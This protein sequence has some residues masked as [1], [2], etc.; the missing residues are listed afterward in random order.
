ME[1][2]TILF[3]VISI[4]FFI[5]WDYF[6]VRKDLQN[7]TFKNKTSVVSANEQ[8]KADQQESKKTSLSAQPVQQNLKTIDTEK[9]HIVLSRENGF[10]KKFLLKNYYKNIQKKDYVD[11]FYTGLYDVYDTLYIN[12]VGTRIVYNDL[13]VA[14][15]NKSIIFNF[16][17]SVGSVDIKK[18]LTVDKSDFKG[19]VYY[20]I[21]PKAPIGQKIS[22]GSAIV[23]SSSTFDSYEEGHPLPLFF[24]NK[25]LEH[26]SEKQLKKGFKALNVRLGGVSEKYFALLFIDEKE[27]M[28]ADST[29]VDGRIDTIL[30]FFEA[31]AVNEPVSFELGLFFGPKDPAVLKRIN[32]DLTVI[33]DY[34]FFHFISKPLLLILNFFYS[35][36]KNY[37]ISIILLTI[38]IKLFFF[39]L[40]QKSYK[41]MKELQKLQP[42]LEEIRKK[43]ANDRETLNREMML[44]YKRH[45]VNPMSGCLPMLVQIPFFIALYQAL[46]SAIELRQAPFMLWIKDLSSADPYYVTPILMG[47]TMLLQQMLTPS[48]GDVMQKRMMYILPV[49]FTFMFINFPSG[50]VLY[51]L[52]NNVFSIIQQ[53]VTMKKQDV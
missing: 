13:Q 16:S 24:Y 14:E 37:G 27:K 22:V 7:N 41:S 32:K 31:P 26:P 49:V 45:G 12:D 44:L 8:K 19:S 53:L 5:F 11:L 38:L 36:T 23:Q 51:W 52:I 6:F 43:Y 9:F 4:A 1:K 42:K 47:A 46:M 29:N 35:F 18:K 20:T 10:F 2:R 21:I 39:P 3:V 50:L 30:T 48:S 15:D 28:S 25:K 17:G 33:V 40:S 34:G